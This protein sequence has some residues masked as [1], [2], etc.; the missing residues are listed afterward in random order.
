MSVNVGPIPILYR[1]QARLLAL[2]YGL[3]DE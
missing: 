1:L 2:V 3:E